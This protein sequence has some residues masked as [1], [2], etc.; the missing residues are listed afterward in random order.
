MTTT[1][2]HAFQEDT[3]QQ[4][5]EHIRFWFG[6]PKSDEEDTACRCGAKLYPLEVVDGD[7][8]VAGIWHTK[9]YSVIYEEDEYNEF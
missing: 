9:K 2:I 1:L 3:T 7:V 8:K 6:F 5:R 4:K